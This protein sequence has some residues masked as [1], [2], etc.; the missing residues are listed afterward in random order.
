[1]TQRQRVSRSYFVLIAVALSGVSCSQADVENKPLPMTEPALEMDRAVT[2]Y[3]TLPASQIRPVLD[4]Y[5]AETGKSVKLVAEQTDDSTADLF[6]VSNL[7][8]LW[9]YAESDT[10]RPTYSATIE[11]NIPPALRDSEFRWTTLATRK[12]FIVYNTTLVNA[13]DLSDVDDYFALGHEKWRGKL[14]MSSSEVPGNRTLVAFLIAQSNLREAEITVR[15]WR[16]NF[17][18][19]VFVDDASLLHAIA[20][21]Q[22]AIGVANSNVLTAFGSANAGA[23]IAPH[24]FADPGKTIVDA[25]G[26]GV[27]RHA[28]SP[29]GAVLLLE[30]LTSNSPNALYAALGNEFPG[31]VVSPVSRSI[32]KWR[33]AMVDPVPLSQLGFLHEDA[34]LL[35]ERARYP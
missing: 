19:G 27:A 17:A 5:T 35:M 18:T 10:F 30:W 15:N 9:K 13:A 31:N 33:N 11:S 3:A 23:A 1:M 16:A 21:G 25:S 20:D 24:F 22:C 12:R 34:V 29:E 7:T 2:V 32:E 26:G 14:C 6:L 28:K 8:E 4:A